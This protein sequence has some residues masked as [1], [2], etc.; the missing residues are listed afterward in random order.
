MLSVCLITKNEEHCIGN[1]LSSIKA[2]ADEIIVVDTG[3]TDRTADIAREF[4][5]AVYNFMWIND[6][7][8]ARNY[9]TTKLYKQ[10]TFAQLPAMYWP[11]RRLRTG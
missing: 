9:S 2:I 6:F 7:S 4:G 11:I 5:A 8:A 1:A 10:R 3:S